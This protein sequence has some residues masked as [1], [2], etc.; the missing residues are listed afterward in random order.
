MALTT[1]VEL[2][3]DGNKHTN[4]RSSGDSNVR[5]WMLQLMLFEL[6]WTISN[7]YL[8]DDLPQMSFC[9]APAQIA[10][11]VSLP[12]I[13][14]HIHVNCMLWKSAHAVRTGIKVVIHAC[15]MTKTMTCVWPS[16]CCHH[17]D[18]HVR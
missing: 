6:V 2:R 12:V 15:K 5:R 7:A 11:Q 16:P 18:S 1:A 9:D 13:R 3:S 10:R 8:M 4:G 17:A 14:C